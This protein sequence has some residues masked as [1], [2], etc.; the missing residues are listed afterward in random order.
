MRIMIIKNDYQLNSKFTCHKKL[1]KIACL[2]K[3]N[4]FTKSLFV[5]HFHE[6]KQ[7]ERT[8]VPFRGF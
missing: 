5:V 6:R 7:I 2:N 1:A 3:V 4:G 8:S